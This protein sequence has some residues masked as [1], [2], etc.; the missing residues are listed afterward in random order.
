[1]STLQCFRDKSVP[2]LLPGPLTLSSSSCC[3]FPVGMAGGA[4]SSVFTDLNAAQLLPQPQNNASHTSSSGGSQGECGGP[5][6]FVLGVQRDY[7]GISRDEVQFPYPLDSLLCL[8]HFCEPLCPM[9]FL[10]GSGLPCI[11]IG[12]MKVDGEGT[13]YLVPHCYSLSL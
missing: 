6:S 12:E 10:M 9:W 2:H 3:L 5:C 7:R 8:G 4:P 11:R 1:M 13:R